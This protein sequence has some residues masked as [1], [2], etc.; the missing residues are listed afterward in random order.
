MTLLRN[1]AGTARERTAGAPVDGVELEVAI[2]R[3]VRELRNQYGLTGR[4][5]PPR[6]RRLGS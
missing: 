4:T 3:N 1:N 5:L 6:A 2:G